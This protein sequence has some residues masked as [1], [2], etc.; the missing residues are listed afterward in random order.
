MASLSALLIELVALGFQKI[1]R[2]VGERG[3]VYLSH[4][5]QPERSTSGGS[6][7]HTSG[8][9]VRA[10]AYSMLFGFAAAAALLDSAVAAQASGGD[11][12]HALVQEKL[13]AIKASAVANQNKLHQYTWTEVSSVTVNGRVLPP[14]TSTCSYGAD[15]KVHKVPAGG[16]EAD[17]GNQRG[18]RLMQRVMEE[19]KAE[20]TAY[21]QRVSHVLALYIPPNPQ[22]MQQ[23]FEARK[24]SIERRGSTA[25]LV[26]TNYA[27]PG[28]SMTIGTDTTS[29]KI[30]S[31]HV[32]SY[33]DTPQ[34]AVLLAVEFARLPDGTN[35]PARTV[36][37]AKGKGIHVVNVNSDYRKAGGS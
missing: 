3:S 31:L 12:G 26:F 34:D 17:A 32:N 10:F 19:K 7:S 37:D 2:Y 29:H 28:D 25:D 5:L 33:L 11:A 9:F 18:G 30:Q 27:L 35:H 24:V 14:K 8:K 36:L 6:M 20:I 4:L 15:G 22:K 16:A 23:A 1:I 13:A 21:M